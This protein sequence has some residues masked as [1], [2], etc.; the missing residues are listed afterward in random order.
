MMI[1]GE[2]LLI[3]GCLIYSAI[4]IMSFVSQ[5]GFLTTQKSDIET[6]IEHKQ[7]RLDDYRTRTEQHQESVPELKAKVTRLQQWINALKRQKT[8][9]ASNTGATESTPRQSRDAAIRKSMASVQ[10]RKV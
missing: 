7:T 2:A 6:A 10:K 8:Q 4:S 1:I 3:L 9:V 5:S